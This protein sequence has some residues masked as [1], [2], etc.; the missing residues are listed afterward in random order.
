[1]NTE[2]FIRNHPEIQ[3]AGIR[4]M[5]CPLCEQQIRIV[6]VFLPSYACEKVEETIW[7]KIKKWPPLAALHDWFGRPSRLV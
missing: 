3:E 4:I 7:Q 1:L 5:I 2:L 6:T